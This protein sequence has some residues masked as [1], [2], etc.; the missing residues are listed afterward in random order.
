MKKGSLWVWTGI[1]QV[2][3]TLPHPGLL[4]SFGSSWRDW[5][6]IGDKEYHDED[7]DTTEKGEDKAVLI[8]ENESLE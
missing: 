4:V 2:Y 6:S 3:N 7:E 5:R 8:T 1:Y